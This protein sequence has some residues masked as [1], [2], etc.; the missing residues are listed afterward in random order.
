MQ[1]TKIFSKHHVSLSEVARRMGI[2]KGTLSD[3]IRRDNM[4]TDTL[5]RI[6]KAAGC[7]VSEFFADEDKQK[8]ETPPAVLKSNF[9][10]MLE[11]DGQMYRAD[12]AK[13]L[14]AIVAKLQQSKNIGTL[15]KSQSAKM[16]TT[17]FRYLDDMKEYIQVLCKKYGVTNAYGT[18]LPESF[19]HNH[20]WGIIYA[21]DA[22]KNVLAASPFWK[23]RNGLYEVQ[24]E[25]VRVGNMTLQKR[26][27]VL[28]FK[29]SFSDFEN[30]S[31]LKSKDVET[32][33]NEEKPSKIALLIKEKGLTV[34]EVAKR[35]G[36]FQTSLSRIIHN[37]TNRQ[38]TLKAIAEAI[39]CNIEDLKD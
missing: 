9:T 17:T 10:V 25:L 35:M 37:G 39:G 11:C 20:Q 24:N 28:P 12:N 14:E 29:K 23:N 21:V 22:N 13:E 32:T 31:K 16:T 38:N 33:H 26:F 27:Q 34:T 36:V 18:S 4:H 6:A 8:E 3:A 19:N 5:R 15:T 1:I 2:S 30:Y 7:N